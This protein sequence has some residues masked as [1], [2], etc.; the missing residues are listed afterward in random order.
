MKKNLIAIVAVALALCCAIGSTVAFFKMDAK[1]I[2]N[3]FVVGNGVK[4]SF[5]EGDD[6]GTAGPT[7][8]VRNYEL[9]PGA[10]VTK[11][12]GIK[13]DKGSEACFI[14]V[15]V[16]VQNN[17]VNTKTVLSFDMDSDWIQLEVPKTE[18]Q[19][20]EKVP[21]VYYQAVSKDAS[22]DQSFSVFD[23]DTVSVNAELT[24]DDLKA[25]NDAGVAPTIEI[26]AYAIQQEGF[27]AATG[28]AELNPAAE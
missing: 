13:V 14:Y 8:G 4:A 17:T 22:N 11:K 20:T 25:L 15:K 28:W 3:I 26:T 6:D 23:G 18:G 16:D 5:D 21:G 9:I 7:E 12:A 27:T 2:T 10:D 24:N 19:G 1:K